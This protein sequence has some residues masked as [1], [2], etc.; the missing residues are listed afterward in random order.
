MRWAGRTKEKEDLFIQV[1]LSIFGVAC[2]Q[3]VVLSAQYP[4]RTSW[5]ECTAAPL[6]S[7]INK[8]VKGWSALLND[9]QHFS[10]SD[11][12]PESSTSIECPS[13]VTVHKYAADLDDEL[14]IS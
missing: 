9:G 14:M 7:H 12:I 10:M 8:R 4:E 2:A 11:D 6:H 5:G 1:R 3:I 13:M